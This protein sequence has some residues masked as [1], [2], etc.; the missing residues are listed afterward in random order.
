MSIADS[1]RHIQATRWV[2]QTLKKD[3]NNIQA[4]LELA[5]MLGTLNQADLPR[6]REVLNR[7]LALEPA[8]E[9]AR[10]ML[11]EMDRA[12]IGGDPSRLSH[13]V[14][15]T[16]KPAVE[17]T[18]EPL[19]LRYSI[20][21]QFLVYSVLALA[22]F[23]LFR[24]FGEWDVFL[25]FAAFASLLI[26]PLWFVSAV[27][28]VSSSGLSLSRL[29]GIYRREMDWNEI[30]ALRPGPM[31]VG[32]KLTAGDVRSLMISSQLHGYSPFVEIVRNM[33]PDLFE[34]GDV[35]TFRKGFMRKFGW[36]FLLLPATPMA[37]GGI[38]VPPFLP[39]LLITAVIL[40]F[41]ASALR[42]AYLVE[43]R[44]DRLSTR[45]LLGRREL[46]ILQIKGIE[47]VTVYN[48]RG[49]AKSLVQVELHDGDTFRLSGF[50]EGNEILY[51]Y[52][53]NWWQANQSA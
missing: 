9:R 10:A 13:A 18:E 37:L 34:A 26:I 31:G 47:M 39:G 52:L 8:N 30:E 51:G 5:S 22:L 28:E 2:Q 27:L 53:K 46:T 15:L 48:R 14:I 36:F 20:F 29:F 44:G 35:K 19:K 50:P 43:V 6:K 41:W 16:P 21:H 24:A 7:I 33:R 25:V 38:V 1:I 23:I 11:F 45:S 3:P 4:L 49:V 17:F 12:A 42:A 32:L 40:F